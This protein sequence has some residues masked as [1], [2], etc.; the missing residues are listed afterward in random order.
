[1]LNRK[2]LPPL[3]LKD[4]EEWLLFVEKAPETLYFVLWLKDYTTRYQQWARH[5]R[6]QVHFQDSSGKKHNTVNPQLALFYSRAK[7]TFF[8]PNSV[9]EL[10]VPSNILS[11]FYAT[12]RTPHPDPE[13]FAELL[14][15][16]EYM[17]R[18]SLRNF[19]L[20][21][22]TNVGTRR[23]TC[24]IVA[25]TAFFLLGCV[26]PIVCSFTRGDSRWLRISA[27]PGMWLGLT[28]LYA[29]LHG[30]CL[31]IYF[32]GDVRQ[33]RKFELLRPSISSPMYKKNL[34][35]AINTH[36]VTSP[37]LDDPLPLTPGDGMP[38]SPTIVVPDSAYNACIEPNYAA[39]EASSLSDG[40]YSHEVAEIYISP[41]YYDDD[42]VEG[43]ALCPALCEEELSPVT[44][45]FPVY[46]IPSPGKAKNV[47]HTFDTTATFIHPYSY[48]YSDD[49]LETSVLDVEQG[50]N[51]LSG[52]PKEKSSFDFAALPESAS[53]T[54]LRPTRDYNGHLKVD[55]SPTAQRSFLNMRSPTPLE[56]RRPLQVPPEEPTGSPRSLLSFLRWLQAKCTTRWR[57]AI[58]STHPPTSDLKVPPP[59]PLARVDDEEVKHTR[60]QFKLMRAVPA[61]ASPL[62]R[63]LSPVVKRA[64]WEITVRSAL[65]SLLTTFL[66][67][68]VLIAAP[69]TRR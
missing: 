45:S 34:A 64:Q 8:S 31:S 58:H 27:F 3:G 36:V 14:Q 28:I 62:T 42:E 33:L 44:D 4:F 50:L 23:A 19:V 24:G 55:P 11:P 30:L 57:A 52:V 9:F 29:S 20:A 39:S 26:A 13:V 68:A 60:A 51:A 41:Q 25:G 69:E 21:S 47:R 1:M 38:Y 46:P 7:R 2:H 22:Y 6:A 16:V 37:P 18:E 10:N 63:V 35:I 5:C 61:F 15:T 54:L 56:T 65:F 17:L 66:I 40:S 67:M 43:P 59:P 49:E 53:V 12:N 48:T 32:F